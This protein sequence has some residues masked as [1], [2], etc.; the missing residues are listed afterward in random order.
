[1]ERNEGDILFRINELTDMH[2]DR[3]EERCDTIDEKINAVR[4][5]YEQATNKNNPNRFHFKIEPALRGRIS[6]KVMGYNMYDNEKY[7]LIEELLEAIE[8]SF[9]ITNELDK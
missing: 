4:N 1:V 6:S 9:G 7:Q 2:L 3:I 8:E 5:L